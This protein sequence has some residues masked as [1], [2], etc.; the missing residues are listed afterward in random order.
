[1]CVCVRICVFV[2]SSTAVENVCFLAGSASH[3][4][5]QARGLDFASA[6]CTVRALL[7][8]LQYHATAARHQPCRRQGLERLLALCII[9]R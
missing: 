6:G 3:E 2:N 1:M 7:A 9:F 8:A 4:G 5:A